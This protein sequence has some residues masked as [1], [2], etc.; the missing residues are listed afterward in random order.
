MNNDCDNKCYFCEDECTKCGG[1][2]N[3]SEFVD[4]L[5]EGEERPF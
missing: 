5:E 3:L 4:K 1:L 2:L